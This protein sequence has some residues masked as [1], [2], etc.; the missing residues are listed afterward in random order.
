MKKLK[1]A[2]MHSHLLY[3][4]GGTKFIFEVSKRLSKD[5]EL[6]ILVEQISDEILTKFNDIGVQVKIISNRSSN[7][8]I[9]WLLFP[10]YLLKEGE[11][12][13]KTLGDYDVLLSSMFPMN[14]FSAHYPNPKV[15]YCYEPYAFFFDRALI[16]NLP[17]PKKIFVKLLGILFKDLDKRAIKSQDLVLTLA[18]GTRKAIQEAYGIDALITYEGVDSSFFKPTK[19]KSIEEK[20]KGWNV[21]V[22]STDFSPIKGTPLA[23]KAFALVEKSL[24]R[25]KFLV[26][27]TINDKKAIKEMF[28]QAKELGVEEKVEYLG[29]VDYNLL[30]A[31]YSRAD[32][33]LHTGLG[34]SGVTAMSLPVKESLACET[35]VIRSPETSDEVQDGISG[36]LI[37]PNDTSRVAQAAIKLLTDEKLSRKMGQQG[38]K[39]IVKNFTWE[40]VEGKILEAL[41]QSYIMHA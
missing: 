38:R 8:P 35:P 39:H 41:K 32:V 11:E 27:S 9:Y 19:D 15:Q 25:T 3:W 5:V 2:W 12:L 4:M 22:H 14:W 36:Y 33:F 21:I 10:I 16:E 1:V 24:P 18:E 28:Q 34:T 20:Y 13:K 23:V 30:P 17:T 7:N 37:D 29:F 6:I 26:T 40:S 31:Y